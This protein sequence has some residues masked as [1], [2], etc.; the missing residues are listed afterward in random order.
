MYRTNV[1]NIADLREHITAPTNNLLLQDQQELPWIR[2]AQMCVQVGG[3]HFEQ[4]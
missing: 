2:R 3:Q 1:T 4:L